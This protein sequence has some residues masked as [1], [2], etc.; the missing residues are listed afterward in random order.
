MGRKTAPL[1]SR[2][3]EAVADLCSFLNE[4]THRRLSRDEVDA[5]RRII[6]MKDAIVAAMA[7][8]VLDPSQRDSK[9]A[10]RR[11]NRSLNSYVMFPYLTRDKDGQPIIENGLVIE[12]DLV[13]TTEATAVGCILLLANRGVLERIQNCDGCGK[14]FMPRKGDKTCGPSCSKKVYEKKPGV[15]EGRNKTGRDNYKRAKERDQRNRSF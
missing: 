9:M 1:T 2:E 11:A 4:S 15:K 13:T 8:S 10:F 3:K 14:T 5:Q 12:E 7:F 6:E